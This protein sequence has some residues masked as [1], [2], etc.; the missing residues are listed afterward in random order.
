MKFLLLSTNDEYNLDVRLDRLPYS[1]ARWPKLNGQ[2]F[3]GEVKGASRR[4]HDKFG[5][6]VCL[7]EREWD[8]GGYKRKILV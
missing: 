2:L 8:V 4:Y 5:H 3:E 1:V 6:Q 7:L